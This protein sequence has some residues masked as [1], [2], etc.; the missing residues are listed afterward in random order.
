MHGNLATLRVVLLS[1]ICAGLCA[2]SIAFSREL[3]PICDGVS[4]YAD[5]FDGRRTFLWRPD[6]LRVSAAA[7]RDGV[8]D[9]AIARVIADAERAMREG[10]WSVT[11]KTRIPESGDR[12]DYTSM[13]PYWWPDSGKPDG[14][15]YVRRDGQINP[16]RDG[17]AYDRT[18]MEAM[19]RAVEA[20]AL[21]HYL[22]GEQRYADRA[23]Q[24]LR[25]WFVDPA[26]RMNPNMN[27]AQSIPG[28]VSGRA[29][30]VID[31]RQLMP[32]VESIGLITPSGALNDEEHK[33]LRD[34][35]ADM[36]RWMASSRIGREERAAENNH[37]IFYDVM[38][39]QFAAFAGYHDVAESVLRAFPQRRIRAQFAVDG[40]LPKELARTRSLHYS[41]WTMS[42]VYDLATLG[43][44]FGVDVWNAADE[45][46]RGLRSATAFLAA[47]AGRERE[48]KWQEI[49]PETVELYG[50]LRRAAR[51]YRDASL[52]S[53]S[54]L[55]R[56]RN[57][58][59]RLNLRL[60]AHDVESWMLR[61]PSPAEQ[62]SK[63][64]S[65]KSMPSADMPSTSMP[66][67]DMK[68]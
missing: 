60:P 5:V 63:G 8:P 15:P 16:E 34:W 58:E 44:C 40:S 32:I 30:G 1:L 22:T 29:E 36:V 62:P 13:G 53:K 54:E 61:S 66:S 45:A 52:W 68:R 28:R 49:E 6:G 11:H 64:I 57:A 7:H 35:F 48:W 65:L 41:T 33:A 26:T 19:S 9:P 37:G 2:P 56:D 23:A 4:G 42:A 43:E 31:L 3:V 12:H 17:E 24:V 59:D 25:M 50:A 39:V 21:A 10:P 18:R 14:L 38:I 27:H 51:G 67:K 20:L 55:Y 46:G 47:Y